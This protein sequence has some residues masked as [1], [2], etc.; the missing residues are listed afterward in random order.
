MK[1]FIRIF[2]EGYET[3]VSN[4]K[5]D[6]L[7]AI[8]DC[9]GEYIREE[10]FSFPIELTQY[11]DPVARFVPSSFKDAYNAKRIHLN[12]FGFHKQLDVQFEYIDEYDWIHYCN[13]PWCDGRCG[14]LSCGACIDV[15]RCSGDR[16]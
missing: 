6:E 9:I 2:V 15:C 4:L 13:D 10:R 3:T 8:G 14:V 7:K 11:D 12:P 16:Y 1:F 5:N